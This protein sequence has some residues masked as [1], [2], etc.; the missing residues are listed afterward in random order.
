VVVVAGTS[1]NPSPL[2]LPRTAQWVTV[3]RIPRAEESNEIILPLAELVVT[4]VEVEATEALREEREGTED[5][6]VDTM[7]GN[8]RELDIS[9]L[10]IRGLMR[11]DD[12][13]ENGKDNHSWG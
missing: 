12:H 6:Q 4:E 11:F 7:I 9:C 2:L 3:D 13:D 8:P 10:R 5:H 1:H